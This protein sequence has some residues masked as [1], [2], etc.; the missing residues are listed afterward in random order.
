M[1]IAQNE[2]D[3][4]NA[5]SEGN[6]TTN[7]Y[8][9]TF[10]TTLTPCLING[11]DCKEALRR[12]NP[13]PLPGKTVYVQGAAGSGSSG[14]LGAIAGIAIAVIVGY[15]GYRGYLKWKNRVQPATTT[16][17]TPPEVKKVV[18]PKIDMAKVKKLEDDVE[19]GDVP[20]S[21]EVAP[22]AKKSIEDSE[23]NQI[24]QEELSRTVMNID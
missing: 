22:P 23:A 10:T 1:D 24:V 20:A 4:S 18:I 9:D 7:P 11:Y 16:D 21:T 3:W 13:Q 14:I 8:Y 19:V 15:S 17:E 2:S 5:S 12:F 6:Q